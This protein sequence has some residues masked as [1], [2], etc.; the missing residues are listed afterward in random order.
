V[1]KVLVSDLNERGIYREPLG[2]GVYNIN[3][4]ALTVYPVPTN[5]IMVD[6]ADEQAPSGQRVSAAY[7]TPTDRGQSANVPYPYLT[8]QTVKG[9][10]YFQFGQLNVVSKD[11]F[12]LEVSVR[13][14]IRVAQENAAFVIARFGSIQDL[15]S[16]IV[17]PLIDSEF[18]NSAGSEDALSFF[19]SRT[20][21]QADALARAKELF[22]QYHV[23]AQN[24]LISYIDFADEKGQKLLDTQ[25]QKQIAT[26]QQAQ[27]EQQAAAQVKNIELQKQQATA[28]KQKDLIASSIQISVNKNLADAAIEQARGTAEARAITGDGESRY[29]SKV[30]DGNAAQ[31]R[32]TGVATADAYT[33]QV[34]ALGQENVAMVKVI[35][36]IATGKVVVTPQTLITSGE[37]SGGS[38]GGLLTLFLQRKIKDIEKSDNPT[39]SKDTTQKTPGTK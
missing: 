18:R 34:N 23:E 26:Q 22:A 39:A 1:E 27:F 35:D 4:V 8:D 15:I 2:P 9:L 6:W 31:I 28:D 10:S 36:E 7:S 37:D 30:A 25:N 13:M 20:K 17:H 3:T 33:A 19:Q 14:I 38:L 32:Q 21:L 24:L 16:Q 12:N 11:V 29:L 5:A